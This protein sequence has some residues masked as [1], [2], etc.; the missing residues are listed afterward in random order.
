MN[1]IKDKQWRRLAI[2]GLQII[3]CLEQ[4]LNGDGVPPRSDRFEALKLMKE[5]L[6]I[7]D[8]KTD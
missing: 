7:H 8:I 2:L 6:V 4:D 5:Y 3:T 1:E